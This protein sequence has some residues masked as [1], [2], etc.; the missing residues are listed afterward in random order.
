MARGTARRAGRRPNLNA[1]RRRNI[2]SRMARASNARRAKR[3]QNRAAMRVRAGKTL[4]DI[5]ADYLSTSG[6]SGTVGRAGNK[7]QAIQGLLEEAVKKGKNRINVPVKQQVYCFECTAV[8]ANVPD[9][10]LTDP[11][12]A[13]LLHSTWYSLA[14]SWEFILVKGTHTIYACVDYDT[15]AADRNYLPVGI[16]TSK[17]ELNRYKKQVLG[18]G[19]KIFECMKIKGS[20]NVPKTPIPGPRHPTI[21][22][23]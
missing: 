21:R 16:S 14:R 23:G 3:A 11:L 20:V 1:F 9:N 7:F 8:L 17:V 5:I 12:A 10:L 4:I 19:F 13:I 2:Q 6:I 22:A 15:V 18:S